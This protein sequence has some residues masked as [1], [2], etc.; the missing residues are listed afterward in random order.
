MKKF[1]RR[2]VK[3]AAVPLIFLLIPLYIIL[4]SKETLS[5]D[6]VIREQ[7]QDSSVLVGCSLT[8]IDPY[9]KAEK[10]RMLQPDILVL[11]TSRT[12]QFRRSFFNPAFSFYNAGGGVAHIHEFLPFLKYTKVKPEVLIIA[13]D[14]YFFNP[15]W[16]T[17][18][19][20]PC[21]YEYHNSAT[22]MLLQNLFQLYRKVGTGRIDWSRLHDSRNIGLLAKMEGDGFRD[23]GS[24]FYNLISR[25][26]S[27]SKDYS[28]KD[29]YHRIQTGSS[30]FEY[31]EIVDSESI[32][33]LDELLA[34]CQRNS[35][36]VVAYLPPYAPAV[37][38]YMTQS[39]EYKEKYR[40]LNQIYDSLYP[41]FEKYHYVLF[42]FSDGGVVGSRDAEFIDGFHGS[43]KTYLRM[44]VEMIR[45]NQLMVAFFRDTTELKQWILK[46]PDINVAR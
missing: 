12:M 13:L 20:P 33:I 18:A 11:G 9:L 24:Y 10:S 45:K 27:E 41:L 38:K 25:Y 28:F 17:L 19:I 46:Y 30:R 3:F 6:E 35:I 44:M 36:Q 15:H 26:P 1:L 39:E 14:Q 7:E 42:D 29:T 22:T 43:D 34:Y 5:L 2:F 16:E 8:Y 40:Y 31:S 23:D 32:R 21:S 37:W 4:A